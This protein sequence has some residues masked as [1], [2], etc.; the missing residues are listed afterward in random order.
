M[1]YHNISK[2]TF[3]NHLP[4]NEMLQF[5]KLPPD[6]G[7]N[8]EFGW[9]RLEK[10]HKGYHRVVQSPLSP[11]KYLSTQEAVI[12]YRAMTRHFVI[13]ITHDAHGQFLEV[14]EESIA[15]QVKGMG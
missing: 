1:R 15:C 4:F 9:I 11:Q 3:R 12:G 6:L 13:C 10:K 7:T 2:T 5:F 8:M 14:V